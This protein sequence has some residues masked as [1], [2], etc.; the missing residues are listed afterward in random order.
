MSEVFENNFSE[1]QKKWNKMWELWADGQADSPYCELMNYQGE[2]NNG[3]HYQYFDN[4]QNTGDLQKEMSVLETIL[5]ETLKL[6]L[7]R[8]YRAYLLLEENC[9]DDQAE[10]IMEQCDNMF[11]E[12]EDY[13]NLALQNYASTIEIPP[14]HIESFLANLREINAMTPDDYGDRQKVKRNNKLVLANRQIAADIENKH[15]ELKEAFAK[16]LMDEDWKIRCNVAHLMLELMNYPGE[17]RKMAL[18][19][20]KS[21]IAKNILVHSLGNKMWLQKWYEDHPEDKLL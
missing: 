5:P 20:I 11:Y 2:V 17:Y 16:L 19:E 13:I 8:A 10:E 3:G 7:Q 21:V 6:N 15:P 4:T 12:K 14:E 9:D 18:D 1:D